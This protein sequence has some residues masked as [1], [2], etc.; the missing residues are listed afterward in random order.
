M[1]RHSLRCDS[2]TG[3]AAASLVTAGCARARAGASRSARATMGRMGPVLDGGL[4]GAEGRT[5]Y[6]HLGRSAA[7][8]EPVATRLAA[9]QIRAPHSLSL[10]MTQLSQQ[11]EYDV[12][13]VGSGAGGGMAAYAL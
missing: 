1:P 2:T 10:P 13:I 4:W 5:T 9:R 11:T 6:I 8:A 3:F 12:C 7:P